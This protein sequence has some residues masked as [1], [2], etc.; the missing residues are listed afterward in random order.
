MNRLQ[1]LLA[2]LGEECGEVQQMVGKSLRFGL[3]SHHPKDPSMTNLVLLLNEVN[4]LNTIVGMIAVE[5]DLSIEDVIKLKHMQDKVDKVE[6][7]YEMFSN[8]SKGS[9]EV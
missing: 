7:Y 9:Q 5:L 3:D 2:C 8:N 6:K 4:D 1:H